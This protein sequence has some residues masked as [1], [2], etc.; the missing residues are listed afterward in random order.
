MFAEIFET[1]ILVNKR[2]AEQFDRQKKIEVRHNYIMK[3]IDGSVKVLVDFP[4]AKVPEA[5]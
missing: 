2:V 3:I 5:Y 4:I 1:I